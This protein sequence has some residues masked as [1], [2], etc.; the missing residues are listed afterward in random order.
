VTR[1]QTSYLVAI[2]PFHL[3]TIP[4]QHALPLRNNISMYT[5]PR[6]EE[7]P[8]VKALETLKITR[9]LAVPP[10]LLALAKYPESRL[11]SL[12]R[13]LVG[14][15]PLPLGVQED[16]YAKLSP[17]ARIIQVYGMT[18]TGWATIWR[19]KKKDVTG[20]IGQTLP[21]SKMRYIRATMSPISC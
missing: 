14:G 9:T 6:F 1:V 11:A 13:I 19:K 8:F 21:G 3:F 5:L 7:G 17:A 15:S 10:I 16:M 2:P 20:S 12:R 18:E 4:V